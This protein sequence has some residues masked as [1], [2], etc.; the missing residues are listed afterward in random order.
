MT[1]PENGISND[2]LSSVEG[3]ETL[4]EWKAPSFQRLNL[5]DAEFDPGIGGDGFGKS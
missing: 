1:L 3:S 2:T 5:A 4:L